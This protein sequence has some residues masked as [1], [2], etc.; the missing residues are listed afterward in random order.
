MCPAFNNNKNILFPLLLL[1]IKDMY[2]FMELLQQAVNDDAW[3]EKSQ[4]S[5]QKEY[6]KQ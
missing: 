2:D 3:N 5:A 6:R 4:S 1:C